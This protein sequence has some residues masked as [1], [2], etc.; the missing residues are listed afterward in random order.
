MTDYDVPPEI[1]V[2]A[3]GPVRVITLNRPDQLNATNH[4]LHQ[5]LAELF[6]QLDADAGARGDEAV[7]GIDAGRAQSDAQPRADLVE[8]AKF[9][10]VEQVGNIADQPMIAREIRWLPRLAR[11]GQIIG[12]G[13]E[14]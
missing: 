8:I 9:G 11:T 12:A 6:P 4:S 5:G 10:S 7:L 2:T 13:V 3:D 14:A 1:V